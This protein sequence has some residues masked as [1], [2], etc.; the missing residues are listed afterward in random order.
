MGIYGRIGG[1]E[2]LRITMDNIQLR[3]LTYY[4]SIPAKRKSD[5][6]KA[7]TTSEQVYPIITK[8]LKLRP[9]G[10]PRLFVQYR[11]QKCTRQVGNVNHLI[12]NLFFVY[13]FIILSIINIIIF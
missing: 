6:T 10:M 13:L 1:R 9:E 12:E 5:N 7:F 2:L 11:F 3:G 4:I 8:Y